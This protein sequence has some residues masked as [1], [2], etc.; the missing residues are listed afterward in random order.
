MDRIA[1]RLAD[2]RPYLFGDRFTAA[3]LTFAS[4]AAIC[5]SPSQYGVAFP[6]VEDIPDDAGRNFISD[7]R[8]HPAGQF[9][10]R[11]YADRPAVRARYPRPPRVPRPV[12]RP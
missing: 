1:E 3:D 4:L 5:I 10:L 11:L 8:Q 7:M 12:S 6:P 2:G 9:V